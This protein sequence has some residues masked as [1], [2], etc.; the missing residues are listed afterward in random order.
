MYEVWIT[1]LIAWVPAY[2][3]K[4][5]KISI[6]T[7]P[8]SKKVQKD[9]SSTI[10]HYSLHLTRRFENALSHVPVKGKSITS[11]KTRTFCSMRWHFSFVYEQNVVRFQILSSNAFIW[12]MCHLRFRIWKKSRH[13]VLLHKNPRET[14][15]L[16]L[17]S[18][19]ETVWCTVYI[20]VGVSS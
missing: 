2:A 13:P 3:I 14:E 18:K 10:C 8:L 16:E 20:N 5:S 6:P 4:Q 9:S 1:K 12:W 11:V 19:E 7:W 15:Q 17:H